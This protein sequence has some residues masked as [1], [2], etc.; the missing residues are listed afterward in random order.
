MG[1]L[2]RSSCAG[3]I[4]RFTRH[5]AVSY[6]MIE[7]RLAVAGSVDATVEVFWKAYAML[8]AS[9]RA[10]LA[11]RILQDRGLLEGVYDNFLIEQAKKVKGRAVS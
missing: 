9:E 1:V 11:E 4:E 5:F 2:R 7:R 3:P 10:A 8:K 6:E